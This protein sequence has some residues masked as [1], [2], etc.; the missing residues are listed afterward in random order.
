MCESVE[1]YGILRWTMEDSTCGKR[2]LHV[3][4]MWE[5][6]CPMLSQRCLFTSPDASDVSAQPNGT[7]PKYVSA[8]ATLGVMESTWL[9]VTHE[10]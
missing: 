1:E 10:L 3:G 8:Y 9:N 2:Y 7:I 5:A 6:S 4:S